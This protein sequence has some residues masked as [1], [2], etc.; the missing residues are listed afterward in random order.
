M[1]QR[2]DIGDNHE[3]VYLN[4]GGE[5]RVAI[6]VFHKTKDGK[7]CAGFVPFRGRAW[8]ACFS[9]EI[10]AWDVLSIDPLT[11]SPSIL[12]RACGDH[13]FIRDG[14]WVQA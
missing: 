5:E 2:I 11:L 3:I 13:G 12:C 8:D 9:G 10:A 6:D 14:K 1:T 4:Y 7:D